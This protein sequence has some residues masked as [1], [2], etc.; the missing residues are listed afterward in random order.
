MKRFWMVWA[1][2][3]RCPTYKHETRASAEDEAERLAREHSGTFHVLECVG[4]CERPPVETKW[5]FCERVL[6]DPSVKTPSPLQKAVKEIQEVSRK[7]GIDRATPG[8]DLTVELDSYQEGI[9]S[10]P[11]RSYSNPHGR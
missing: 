1:E 5:T 7:C 8:G 11:R 2:R 6:R 10:R 4:T 3:G 9:Y